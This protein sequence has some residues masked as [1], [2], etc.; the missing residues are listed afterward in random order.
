[1]NDVCHCAIIGPAYPLRGGIAQLNESLATAFH[2]QGIETEIFSFSLQYPSILFPGKSQKDSSGTPPEGVKIHSVINSIN[3]LNWGSVADRI[4]QLQPD[5]VVVRYWMPFFA[6]CLGTIIRKIKKKL[7]Q[8]R[9]VA[10]TDNIIPHETRLGDAQLTGY[11]VNSC[12]AFVAMSQAV[13]NDLQNFDSSKP[14]RLIHH[15]IY[16][17][18]GEIIDKA[19]ARSELGL[20]PDGKYVLF[21]GLVRKYK[22]LDLLL[23]AISTVEDPNVRL[24]VAGEFYEQKAEI[25]GLID[26]LGLQDRVILTDQFVAEAD[27]K[28]YFCAADLVVQPYRTATQSGVTQIAYHFNKPML[29]TNVGGL[30]EMIPNGKVGYVVEVDSTS[31]AEAINDFYQ[32]DR[33]STFSS[34]AKEE[35]KRFSWKAMVD[36]I[37]HLTE[38]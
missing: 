36:G 10:L 12:D 17:H 14:R 19:E 11:F 8:V 33:E 3:P 27:V 15:P 4:I 9:I 13:L 23:E 34:N 6:P 22:G 35:K 21:F 29:V 30:P 24:I 5:L 31:I 37:L 32:N 25:M 38:D 18:F 2:Q 20:N 16:D 1:M 28:K 26:S 7:P